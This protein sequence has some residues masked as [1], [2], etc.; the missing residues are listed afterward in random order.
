[1]VEQS[2][3]GG[4][5]TDIVYSPAGVKLALMNATS[6]PSLTKAFVPLPAGD[7][8]VYTSSGLEYYRHTDWLNSSRFAS[9]T[10][11]TPYADYAYSPF[12]E[13]YAQNGAI[14]PSFTGQNQDTTAGLYDFLF[15]EYDPN[16]TRWT[17]PDPAGLSAVDPTNPQSWNRY[18]YVVN[19]PLVFTDPQGLWLVCNGVFGYWYLDYSIDGQYQG[20]DIQA[21]GP[22]QGCMSQTSQLWL[23]IPDFECVASGQTDCGGSGGGVT[24]TDL[25]QLKPSLTAAQLQ[26]LQ[27]QQQAA[28]KN[29]NAMANAKTSFYHGELQ[30]AI[31]TELVVGLGGCAIGAGLGGTIGAV[32]T[33]SLTGAEGGAAGGCAGVGLSAMFTALP[34]AVFIGAINGGLDYFHVANEATQQL[35]EDLQACGN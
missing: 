27:C 29:Q 12:G 32:V 9:T 6:T 17:Q 1:M 14:D 21:L 30:G 2:V 19:N 3:S 16:Q 10:S 24:S 4:S 18:A 33:K 20:T 13:P 22:Y 5:N 35:Q 23:T 15:R 25:S 8:A 7:T 31:A 34:S 26:K 28:A 11:Q